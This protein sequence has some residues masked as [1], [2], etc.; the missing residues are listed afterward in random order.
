ME[1][2][3]SRGAATL[4][5][6]VVDLRLLVLTTLRLVAEHLGRGDNRDLQSRVIGKE[7]LHV[8]MALEAAPSVDTGQVP[9]QLAMAFDP[10]NSFDLGMQGKGLPKAATSLH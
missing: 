4:L 10:R 7:M 3:G 5:F 6:R 1:E 9:N 2:R 8:P